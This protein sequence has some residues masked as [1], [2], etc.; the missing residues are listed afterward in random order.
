MRI[1]AAAKLII[2]KYKYKTKYKSVEIQ[3]VKNIDEVTPFKK[4]NDEL[5]PCTKKK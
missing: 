4:A 5:T 2:T 3:K 1:F